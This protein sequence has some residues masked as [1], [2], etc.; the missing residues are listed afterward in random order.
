VWGV[1]AFWLLPFSVTAICDL[2]AGD[3]ELSTTPLGL[4]A[5]CVLE[6]DCPSP[7][8]E[9][10]L[11]RPNRIA[12]PDPGRII[13]GRTDIAEFV[14]DAGSEKN[15]ENGVCCDAVD[16]CADPSCVGNPEDGLAEVLGKT[17]AVWVFACARAGVVVPVAVAVAVANGAAAFPAKRFANELNSDVSGS[18]SPAS[19]VTELSTGNWEETTA[20]AEAVVLSAFARLSM[21]L[22]DGKLGVAVVLSFARKVIVAC[23]GLDCG[24]APSLSDPACA[25]TKSV[26]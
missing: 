18:R 21:A 23:A 13:L 19:C 15:T 10:P 17:A 3:R 22:F 6:L 8:D 2:L 26:T 7:I 9:G 12:A 4:S 24:A 5:F 25:I 20:G 14:A 16:S 1:C 11:D